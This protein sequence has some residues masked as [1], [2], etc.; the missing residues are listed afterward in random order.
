MFTVEED[1]HRGLPGLDLRI[2]AILQHLDPRDH[3]FGEG[4][5]D[6]PL[7]AISHSP[8]HAILR[9]WPVIPVARLTTVMRVSDGG[10]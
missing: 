3:A 1:P 8:V 7:N 2:L 4:L 5:P 10:D 6:L 9:Q